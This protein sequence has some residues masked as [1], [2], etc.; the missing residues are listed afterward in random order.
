MS[1]ELHVKPAKESRD[2]IVDG[3]HI[4]EQSKEK[5]QPIRVTDKGLYRYCGFAR[6]ESLIL[7]HDLSKD[8]GA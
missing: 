1:K 7:Q 2:I 6:P 8:C 4:D 5:P 3:V